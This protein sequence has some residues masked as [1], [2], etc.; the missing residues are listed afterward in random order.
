MFGDSAYADRSHPSRPRAKGVAKITAKVP[1]TRN[2]AGRFTKDRFDVDPGGRAPSPAR[3]NTRGGH[4]PHPPRWRPGL[5][6]RPTAGLPAAI[7]LHRLARAGRTDRRAHRTRRCC[8]GPGPNSKTRMAGPSA[9]G[10][11]DRSSSARSPTSSTGPRGAQEDPARG[12]RRIA[13]DLDTRAGALNWA[14][15]A[16]LGLIH[17]NRGWAISAS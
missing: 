5:L 16:V 14:R 7:G 6:S 3:P 9:T 17:V 12:L 2:A 8:N 15:L 4:P 11:T 1:P 13:T 10:P